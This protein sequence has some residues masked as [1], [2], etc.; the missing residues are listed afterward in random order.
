MLEA[1]A[2]WIDEPGV[3][4]LRRQP[5]ARPGDGEVLVRTSCTGISRGT[6]TSVFLGRVPTSERERM[7]A[8][9]QEGDFPGPVKYGYLNVGVV[10]TGAGGA[11]RPHRLHAVP[12]S[13]RCSSFPLMP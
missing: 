5:I 3:G 8:P 7:R 11:P 6:E 10:E 4:A 13:V 2:F 12:P 1:V 9:F